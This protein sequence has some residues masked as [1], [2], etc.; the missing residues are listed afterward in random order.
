[1]WRQGWLKIAPWAISALF[2]GA[3]MAAGC[4]TSGINKGDLNFF[5]K[6][7]E[8]ELGRRFSEEIAQK[9]PLLEDREITDYFAQ[10]GRRIAANSDWPDLEFHFYVVDSKEI[11]AF[12]IPGGHVYLNRGLILRADNLSEVT[13]VLGHEISHVVARH[14][15]EQLSKQYG[16][17]IVAQLVLGENPA[18]WQKITAELFGTLGLLHYGRA[19]ESEADRLGVRYV[20]KT[21]YDPQGMISFFEKLL[22][23]QKKQ[24]G[25]L[26][27]L[28][29]THPPTKERIEG[30]KAE[31]AKLPPRKDL[32]RDQPRFHQIQERLRSLTKDEDK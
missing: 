28:F 30:V 6:N 32:V 21:G 24:P 16:F 10:I 7:E 14:G 1:M 23:L 31:I 17:A 4:A 26:D 22:A 19:A 25:L 5:S 11:N 13:G 15:T 20:Y 8:I 29:S 27:K 18:M 12:A 3:V 9:Y 2:L